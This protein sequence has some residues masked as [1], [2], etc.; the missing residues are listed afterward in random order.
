MLDKQIVGGIERFGSL[1][2]QSRCM[3]DWKP[4][5]SVPRFSVS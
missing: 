2:A 5:G 4:A 3:A 1:G